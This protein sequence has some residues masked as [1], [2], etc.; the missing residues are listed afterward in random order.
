MAQKKITTLYA[1]SMNMKKILISLAC[2]AI[3]AVAGDTKIVD[4][5][6]TKIFTIELQED[7]HVAKNEDSLFMFIH[8]DCFYM[9]RATIVEDNRIAFKSAKKQCGKSEVKVPLPSSK[10]ALV[11][12]EDGNFGILGAK[13]EDKSVIIK[14]GRKLTVFDGLN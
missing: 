13:L 8:N 1:E 10:E 11:T 14:K 3:T 2:L 5:G 7:L 6:N 12:G 9:F 4:N